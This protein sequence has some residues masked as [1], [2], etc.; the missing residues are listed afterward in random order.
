MAARRDGLA[1]AVCSICQE[2]CE[3][4]ASDWDVTKCLHAFHQECLHRWVTHCAEEAVCSALP[5]FWIIPKHW[6]ISMFRS[7]VA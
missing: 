6:P 1:N 3:P 5:S 4:G 7:T 2:A